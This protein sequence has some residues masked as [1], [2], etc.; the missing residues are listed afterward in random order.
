MTDEDAGTVYRLQ[1]DVVLQQAVPNRRLEETQDRVQ[2]SAQ[3]QEA[4]LQ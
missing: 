1:Q 4:G 3:A 2:T